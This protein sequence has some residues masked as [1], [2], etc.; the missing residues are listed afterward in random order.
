MKKILLFLFIVI[1]FS[2]Y[3]QVINAVDDNFTFCSGSNTVSGNI[4]TN[5]TINGVLVTNNVNLTITIPATGSI[6]PYIE[7][8]TGMVKVPA[9][10][11]TGTYT[12]IYQIC[13]IA[14]PTNCD[15]GVAT[16]TIN[17]QL[18]VT[19]INNPATCISGGTIVVNASGGSAPYFYSIGGVFEYSNTFTNLI[20]GVTYIVRVKD[21]LGCEA[22]SVV[23]IAII[24]LLSIV[25]NVTDAI[26]NGSTGTITATASGGSAPYIYSINGSSNVFTS[27]VGIFS[28]LLTGVYTVIVTDTSGCT[29]IT[30]VIITEPATPITINPV[31][32][33][34]TL[35][36]NTTGGTPPYV[37]NLEPLLSGFYHDNVFTGLPPGAYNVIAQDSRGC[38]VAQTVIVGFS[39]SIGTSLDTPTSTL[40]AHIF[41]GTSVAPYSYQWELNGVVIAGATTES[42]NVLGQFGLFSVTVTDANGLTTTASYNV[43]AGTLIAQD[44][45][46]TVYPSNNGISISNQSVLANDFLDG[47]PANTAQ[48]LSKIT[49]T[50]IGFPTGFLLNS[51]GT[52]SILPGTASGQ[53]ALSYQVCEV[54]YPAFCRIA[55]ATVTVVND[56]ILLKAFMDTNANNIQDNGEPNFNQGQFTY[57]L[58]D[59]GIVNNVSSSNGEYLINESNPA[60]S[61]DLNYTIDPAY[62]L[63]YHLTT[64]PYNNVSISNAGVITYNFAITQIPFTDLSVFIYPY[65][66]PPR[67][68]FTYVNQIMYSNQGNQSIASGTINF[69]ANNVTTIT[70]ISSA[71]T[72]QTTNGFSYNFSNLLP[73]E[74]RFISITM[75][76]PTIPTVTLGQAL[77]NS[78]S[79]IGALGDINTLNN[80]ASLSQIIV[81]SYDPNDKVESHGDKISLATF[82][83]S[84]YLTYTI[85]FENTGTFN[86]ENVRVNDVLDNKLDET[87][88][89]MVNA[90]HDYSLSRVG[91][92][93][94][95]NFNG[96]QLPPSVAN[97][98]V[99]HGFVTFQIKPK[100][101]YGVG[102]IIPNKADIFFDFN[103]AIV[104][105]T[106][107]TEFVSSLSVSSF[108]DKAFITYP[109]PTNGIVNISLKDNFTI[110]DTIIVNDVLGKTIQNKKINNSKAELDLSTFSNGI[111]FV[112]IQSEG[113]EKVIKVVK[114]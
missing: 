24:P 104:T 88:L 74:S 5:D 51:N 23:T 2:T 13:D 108:D 80:D 93:L 18:I 6:V 32:N 101:G 86:A 56:G 97:T 49:L 37:Y 17:S 58:N 81:G 19:I 10:T 106:F 1:N 73:G 69:M 14:N 94:N 67:P 36:I 61:Y 50:P 77:T 34:S 68:G 25:T 62:A 40:F 35:T 100:A 76:V 15:A 38:F 20:P 29:A 63:Q 55:T 39:V 103:P 43:A 110:I 21:A 65:G 42:L 95:W 96:I 102:D 16:I 91:N 84:D 46:F 79:S 45:F 83:S 71:P 112:K 54:L 7:N 12:I 26:C 66:A 87:S 89:V 113:L 11:P 78:V 90:S 47:F 98:Q 92:N 33:G 52:I 109:N 57:I 9:N 82:K 4:L 3:S 48:N 111:Y 105:N 22:Y 53:Y 31:V 99:G 107:K 44:D 70:T 30:T 72:S 60:N 114:E 75:Q 85:Q 64:A 41:Q 28:G 59:N 27:S 8:T